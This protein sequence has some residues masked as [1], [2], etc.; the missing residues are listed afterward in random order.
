M[1]RHSGNYT[2]D[3][4]PVITFTDLYT[5]FKSNTVQ[6]TFNPYEKQFEESLYKHSLSDIVAI[7]IAKSYYKR[8]NRTGISFNIG[9]IKDD[10]THDNNWGKI[11]NHFYHKVNEINPTS[12][13][14][15]SA[16]SEDSPLYP[17][18]GEI[19]I[20]K[21]NVNVF[22]SSWDNLYYT[23]SLEA[24]R[25]EQVPGTLDAI[26]ERSYMA[27]TIM[28]VKAIYDLTTFTSMIVNTEEELDLILK[29]SN[30][31][32]D[33]VVFEDSN[34][35]VIDFYMEDVVYKKLKDDGVLNTLTRFINPQDS[36]GDKTSLIDDTESYVFKNLLD[37]YT[38][39]GISLYVRPQKETVSNVI[40][41]STLAEL[42]STGFAEDT[43]YTYK[44]HGQTP[45]NFRLIY[46]KRLG[47]SYDIRPMVKIKS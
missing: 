45:L 22:R 33:V 3:L 5:H 16:S 27:S 1:V 6:F 15:L 43:S 40:S 8:Y 14:K 11:K 37:L 2:V 18:I 21:K 20:D 9:F 42:S 41:S 30:N 46:N 38:I 10:G 32:T 25:T 44:M 24:G 19:A 35:V 17:L 7:N 29:N 39:N 13:T 23:R 34:R 4:T 26:E 31:K 28:T 36:I 12:V 47:Y